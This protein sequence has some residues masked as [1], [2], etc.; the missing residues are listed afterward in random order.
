[1]VGGARFF[2]AERASLVFFLP[3]SL[4]W[5]LSSSSVCWRSSTSFPS[6][7]AIKWERLAGD[8]NFDKRKIWSHVR[9]VLV[10]RGNSYEIFIIG[11]NNNYRSDS[12]LAWTASRHWK[13]VGGGRKYQWVKTW[14]GSC[15]D[16]CFIPFYG[17]LYWTKTCPEKYRNQ[18]IKIYGEY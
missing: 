15:K 6:K 8:D 13:K 12:L 18:W 16:P 2:P 1:M 7:L 9:V 5:W 11:T 14:W 17:L 3:W 10:V 4:S